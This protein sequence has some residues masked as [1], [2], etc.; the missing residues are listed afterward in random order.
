M[1]ILE[2]ETFGR[3]GLIH[4]T[5]NLSCALAERGH[6][7]TLLT[8]AGYEL[9]E[10]SLPANLGVVK[11]LARFTHLHS[12]KIPARGLGPARSLEALADSL[13][14]AA[15]ARRLQPDVIHFH[16]TNTSSLAYLGLLRWLGIPITATAHVVTPHERIRFQNAIYH[17]IHHLSHLH[18]AHSESDRRRLEGEFGVTPESVVVIPH[19]EYGFF[20]E[21]FEAPDPGSA[22]RSLG[23]EP[24]DRVALF[25]G[26]IREYKGLD[27]LLEA[28]PRVVDA[29]PQA[30]L[31]VA[32][33]ASRLADSRRQEL[34]EQ[35]LRSGV[36]CHL[37]YIPFSEV[38]RY[39][40]AADLLAM[41][42]RHISQS[43]VLY[44]ALSLGV[45]VV[46]TAVGA[47]PEVL[48]DGESALLIP[49]ES[50][51]DLAQALIRLLGDDPLRERLAQGGRRVG[52]AHS[53]PAI[54]ASTEKAFAS[55]IET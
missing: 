15:F 13:R 37:E 27:L 12:S 31:V 47:L 21:G 53:W 50:P 54:A 8:T 23:L 52:A 44:L 2:I 6:E 5:Y 17:R 16:S 39:F 10:R 20:A 41:P 46:A 40:R 48:C 11:L 26:Y 28:W 49:P 34:E 24:Q 43:G 9:E 4:Y 33:D 14:V 42:Y 51:V 19:G 25:F 7:V 18:I 30:R 36:I 22:R 32:G 29:L 3:G 38:A 35:A 55:L 1:R 45:P